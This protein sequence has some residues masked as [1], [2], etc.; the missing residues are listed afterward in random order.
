MARLDQLRLQD[1]DDGLWDENEREQR[2][3]LFE[4]VFGINYNPPSCSFS[5]STLRLI[6]D[7]GN[8]L[9]N[10]IN[11]EGYKESQDDIQAVSGVVEDIRDA[12]LDY[13]VCSDK[14][15]ATRVQLKFGHPDRWHSNRRYTTRTAS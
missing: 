3:K 4:W 7:T 5:T 15:Y 10:R 12:L 8:V 11:T 6:R 1:D 9:Y 2:V 13:Q 14:S